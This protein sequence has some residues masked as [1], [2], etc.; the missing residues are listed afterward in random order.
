MLSDQLR[1]DQAILTGTFFYFLQFTCSCL[2]KEQRLLFSFS[3]LTLYTFCKPARLWKFVDICSILGLILPILC[4]SVMVIPMPFIIRLMAIILVPAKFAMDDNGFSH[5]II[6]FNFMNSMF[7][8]LG[9]FSHLVH[10]SYQLKFDFMPS[11]FEIATSIQFIA[12]DDVYM[13]ILGFR[14]VIHL[15]QAELLILWL[16]D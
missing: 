4:W 12:F 10:F 3:H 2:S 7:E 8:P 11:S 14:A 1:V 6:L 13:C 5:L 16:V 9:S 15:T